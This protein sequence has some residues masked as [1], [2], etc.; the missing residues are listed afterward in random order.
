MTGNTETVTIRKQLQD[1]CRAMLLH[2]SA[3]G[4]VRDLPADGSLALIDLP[5][6]E[7]NRTP[8]HQ[9]MTLHQTLARAVAPALPE[10]LLKM[11]VHR[12][13]DNRG[14]RIYRRF[15]P[16]PAINA[17]FLVTLFLVLLLVGF[18]GV[19]AW[20]AQ[21]D[22]SR[23]T[24][25]ETLNNE[26]LLDDAQLSDLR[27][28]VETT[29]KLL[30]NPPQALT[31]AART[32]TEAQLAASKKTIA[33]C[34]S[35][36]S[37]NLNLYLEYVL[38]ALIGMMGAAYSSIYDSFSY[39]REGRYDSSLGTTYYIRIFLGG[40]SGILLAK[41]LAEQG[42]GIE[43]YPTLMLA[44]VGGFATQLVYDLLNKV[45][46]SVANMFRA[47]R[48]KERMEIQNQAETSARAAR[49]ETEEATRKQVAAALKDAQA[50]TDPAARA[51][52]LQDAIMDLLAG[53]I[54]PTPGTAAPEALSDL[55][56]RETALLELARNLPA[57]LPD[58]FGAIDL[59]TIDS[60]RDQ[61]TALRARLEQGVDDPEAQAAA[62]TTLEEIRKANPARALL[63]AVLPGF[64]AGAGAA[65]ARPL[66]EA[67]ARVATRFDANQTARWHW[68]V[69]D[70]E[71]AALSDLL[72]GADAFALSGVGD[73]DPFAAAAHPLLN[74]PARR[75]EIPQLLAA[76][77]R[78]GLFALLGGSFAG[79]ASFDAALDTW[80]AT[81]ARKLLM[82]DLD[83]L[84]VPALSTPI[85]AEALL[86]SAATHG[87]SDAGAQALQALELIARHATSTTDP[88]AA[89]N[90]LLALI[91][92]QIPSRTE[93]EGESA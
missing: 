12:D 23:L 34:T 8:L 30:E 38:L 46:D 62:R 41:P 63:L 93:A 83:N 18:L 21:K 69:Y 52:A 64:A 82:A 36:G 77:N 29:G 33:Q 88:E 61:L 24:V 87:R 32:T 31:D 81:L 79:R 60:L 37:D 59:A 92:E 13:Q 75:E 15:A 27:A 84:I 10:T 25:L 49:I 70:A 89:V 14:F 74:D 55:L 86:A 50:L 6:A 66:A 19:D 57:D 48:R 67:A 85:T 4:I 3:R 73:S 39:V 80:A 76:S 53:D 17:L 7:L 65:T 45:V 2:L 47:D 11:K 20:T 51:K 58:D 44:F 43:G 9:L 35:P 90:S 56:V 71:P 54:A 5:G 68:A 22:Q 1:E 72:A 78:D 28:Y 26:C 42:F 91:G 40:F 16:L